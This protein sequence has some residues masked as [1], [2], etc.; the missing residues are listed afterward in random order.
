MPRDK[1]GFPHLMMLSEQPWRPF[2][3]QQIDV[4]KLARNEYNSLHLF[5]PHAADSTLANGYDLW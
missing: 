2:I 4:W 3:V 5:S 1:C